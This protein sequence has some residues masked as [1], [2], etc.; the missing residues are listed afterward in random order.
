MAKATFGAGCFWGVEDVFM[1]TPGV[2]ATRVGYTGGHSKNPSYHDVCSD[3][4]GHAEAVE[5]TYDPAKISYDQLLKVFWDNHDPT[6]PNQQGPDFG[7]QYRSA[8]FVHDKEQQEA[9]RA[10]KEEQDTTGRFR[11]PIV[12]EIVPADEFWEAEDYH[13]QYFA[14][15]GISHCRT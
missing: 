15:R 13:Q 1:H 4:T 5:V 3:T 7:T 14:K 9:A 12:T 8:I 11:R 6:T 2:T 10:S